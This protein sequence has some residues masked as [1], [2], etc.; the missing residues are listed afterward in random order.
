[1]EGVEQLVGGAERVVTKPTDASDVP[2]RRP[3]G[4]GE[5]GGGGV[6]PVGIDG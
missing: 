6:K 5:S 1:M 3:T 2:N 4:R